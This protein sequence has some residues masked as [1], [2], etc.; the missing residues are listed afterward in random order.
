MPFRPTFDCLWCGAP[1]TC[2]GPDDLEGWAMLCPDCLGKA[3]DNGFLRFRLRQAIEERGRA[4]APPADAAAAE[5]AAAPA[6]ASIA[7]ATAPAPAPEG[8]R[9]PPSIPR[10]P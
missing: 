4:S 6:P 5:A 1:H 7:P 8:Q 2:R 3:G 10:L 9:R